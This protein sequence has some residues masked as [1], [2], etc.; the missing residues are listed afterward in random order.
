MTG[1]NLLAPAQ[2]KRII[3]E[4]ERLLIGGDMR[5]AY[6]GLCVQSAGQAPF[7]RGHAQPVHTVLFRQALAL[8][9]IHR[10][11][12]KRFLPSVI[13]SLPHSYHDCLKTRYQ[14]QYMK[15]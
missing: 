8:F 3:L 14:S 6:F 15:H 7:C 4:I 1:E 13:V 9:P 5:V 12:L 10:E 2:L 11:G